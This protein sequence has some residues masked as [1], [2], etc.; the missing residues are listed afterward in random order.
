MSLKHTKTYQNITELKYNGIIIP[1]D[2]DEGPHIR[3][4]LINMY[5]K[6]FP[7]FFDEIISINDSE[8]NDSEITDSVVGKK[9]KICDNNDDWLEHK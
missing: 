7:E 5:C 2:E 9:R 1:V 4:L 3:Q 8:I 6:I